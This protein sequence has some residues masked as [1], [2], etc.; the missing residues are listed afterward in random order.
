MGFF[1]GILNDARIRPAPTTRESAVPPINESNGH[2]KPPKTESKRRLFPDGSESAQPANPSP[3]RVT[4]WREHDQSSVP[5]PV[6]RDWNPPTELS[7]PIESSS[8]RREDKSLNP[9]GQTLNLAAATRPEE[10]VL[11]LNDQPPNLGSQPPPEE[12]TDRA[13]GTFGAESAR[14]VHTL[15]APDSEEGPDL[16]VPAER[17]LRERT[18]RLEPQGAIDD[19]LGRGIDTASAAPALLSPQTVLRSPDLD[20][21]D[22]I[23]ERPNLTPAARPR[24]RIVRPPRNGSEEDGDEARQPKLRDD[25][26]EHIDAELALIREELHVAKAEIRDLS[27]RPVIRPSPA[28]ATKAE[29]SRESGAEVRIGQID[30]IVEGRPER[31]SVVPPRETGYASRTYLRRL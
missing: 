21:D 22:R 9:Q 20:T 27:R 30:V 1:N 29:A 4:S 26:V 15:T 12:P 13:I 10:Q 23:T 25:I 7:A 16:A 14:P 3:L 18:E 24:E 8:R 2:T 17:D 19:A 28:D 6:T 31:I 11:E 5:I